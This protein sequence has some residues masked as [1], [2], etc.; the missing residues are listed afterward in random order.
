MS[1]ENQIGLTELLNQLKQELLEASI[2]SSFKVKGNNGSQKP[3][4]IP[5]FAY[6]N[7]QLELQ[8]TVKKEGG[9]GVKLYLFDF[10]GGGSRDDVQKIKMT[11]EPLFTKEQL[12]DILEKNNPKFLEYIKRNAPY[13][14]TKGSANEN[15]DDNVA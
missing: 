11:L 7:I 2:L 10:K 14:V 3:I 4:D 13:A 5:L 6:G 8:V 12:L 1:G 9:A 15:L